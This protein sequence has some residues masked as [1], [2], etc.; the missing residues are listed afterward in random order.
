M[1]RALWLLL[2]GHTVAGAVALRDL[3]G[4]CYLAALSD[5]LP[6]PVALID[7]GLTQNSEVALMALLDTIIGLA[8]YCVA[9]HGL[10]GLCGACAFRALRL[11]PRALPTH[12]G[13]RLRR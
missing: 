7:R 6:F 9:L 3:P 12:S 13:V 1:A 4:L 10:T 5:A 11:D 2:T 8:A